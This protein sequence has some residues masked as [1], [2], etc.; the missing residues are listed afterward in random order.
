M[1]TIARSLSRRMLARYASG[2]AEHSL[3]PLHRY[4]LADACD[5]FG[6]KFSPSVVAMV[7]LLSLRI[8]SM[9]QIDQLLYGPIK[10]N[11]LI[12]IGASLLAM[13]A[14][15]IYIRVVIRRP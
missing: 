7:M 1:G 14:E 10:L 2:Q 5:G 12:D 15:A 4:L 3:R 9:H 13:G 8:I 6:Q 11:W